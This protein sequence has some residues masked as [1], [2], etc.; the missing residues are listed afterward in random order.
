MKLISKE[1]IRGHIKRKYDVPKTPCQ[2]V[3]ES[4][5]IPKNKKQ[6]LRKLYLSL[7]PAQLKRDIDGKLDMLYKAYQDKNKTLKVDIN[8]KLSVRFSDTQSNLVSVR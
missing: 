1:R 6:E 7:N 2:R 3:M 4:K 8:K 5:D